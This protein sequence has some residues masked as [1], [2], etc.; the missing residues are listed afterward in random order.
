MDEICI[1]VITYSETK[2]FFFFMLKRVLYSYNCKNYIQELLTVVQINILL[3]YLLVYFYHLTCR[4]FPMFCPKQPSPYI[5]QRGYCLIERGPLPH[6]VDC[7]SE[8]ISPRVP[9]KWP[10]KF[11]IEILLYPFLGIVR[12][13]KLVQG[14]Q[15]NKLLLD[16]CN[17]NAVSYCVEGGFCLFATDVVGWGVQDIALPQQLLG[18]EAILGSR[19]QAKGKSGR[20]YEPPKSFPVEGIFA[21]INSFKQG[22]RRLGCKFPCSGRVPLDTSGFSLHG[23]SLQPLFKKQKSASEAPPDHRLGT[24]YRCLWV[25]AQPAIFCC[26]PLFKEV[27]DKFCQEDRVHVSQTSQT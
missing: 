10:N 5:Q 6:V 8:D 18:L 26:C 2:H 27:P 3:A 22:I 7:P 14:L 17:P 21:I 4:V 9:T 24:H 1:P 25:S 16:Q 12:A 19:P 15:W 13:L 20:S 23:V 11:A